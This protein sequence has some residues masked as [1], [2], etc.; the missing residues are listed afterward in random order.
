M[1]RGTAQINE[2]S[3][4]EEKKLATVGENV[5]V[6]L[7]L[8]IDFFDPRM[9]VEFVDL[10]FVIEVADIGHDGLVLHLGH[11]I[12]GD[13]VLVACGGDVDV[14]AAEGFL[15]SGHFKTFHGGLEGVDGIDFGNDDAGTLAAERLGR[16]FADVAIAA[17]DSD[18]ARDHNVEGAVESV[19]E[20]V[21]ATV[22]VVEL[23]LGDRVVDVESGDEKFADLLQFI[24]AMD[25]SGSFLGYAFPLFDHF[26]ENS[27]R[28]G[29]NF[30]KKVFNDL[31][32]FA[33]AGG[34]DP[35]VAVFEFIAF[36]KEEGD[37]A[38]VI[39]DELRAFALGVDDRL[40]GAV[41]VLLE[42][43]ALPSEDGNASG[44][45]GG[46]GL[47]LSGENIATG[48][49]DISAKGDESLDEDSGLD[50]HVKG[51]SHTD[52][53]ER[54]GFGM[55]VA[56]RHQSG[57]F[58]LGDND[59]FATELGEGDILYMIILCRFGGTRGGGFWG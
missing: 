17:D 13:D 47:I 6:E 29:V 40:P 38:P 15:D 39:D 11:V 42:G 55:L 30:F 4:C 8:N 22:E 33:G 7:G 36:V 31:L 9:V 28:F 35:A 37:V 5:L 19:D 54:L 16:A 51:T 3:L 50:G 24:E 32:F 26:V 23:G 45:D 14:G 57:H 56:D 59:F 2:T 21:T 20:G 44:C 25:S 49:A 1:A 53:S 12:E 43:F 41:P 34:I 10:D 52:A 46:S 48:P 27:W 58:L 18:F